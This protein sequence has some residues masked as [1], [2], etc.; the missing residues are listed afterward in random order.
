MRATSPRHR[1]DQS[2]LVSDLSEPKTSSEIDWPPTLRAELEVAPTPRRAWYLTIGPAYLTIFVWAPFFDPL[3][4][5]DLTAAGLAWLAGTA[6]VSVLLC[7]GLFYYPAAM[8]G[9]RTGRKLGVVA[10][11]TFG[12]TGSDWLTGIV[13]AGAEVVWFA[14]AIDYGIQS[15]LLGLVAGGLLPPGV[16]AGWPVG[17]AI[18]RGPLVLCLA[19]FWIFITG[20][21]SMLRLTSV[22]GALMKVYSPVAL[23]LLTIT[24]IWVL[25]GVSSFQSGE[26][27]SSRA[28]RPYPP[29]LSTI[30]IITGFFSM[31]GLMSVEWGAASARRRDVVV[32]GLVGIVLAGCWTALMSLLVVAGAVG[33]LRA[34][35]PVDAATAAAAPVLSFRWAVANGIGGG[36]AAV[37]L[38]LFGLAALAPACFSSF[39]FIRKLFARWPGI[40]RITWGWIGCTLAF[41]LVVT[42]WPGRLEAV[43]HM[44]GLVFAPAVGAIVGDHLS[45][46]GQWPGIRRGLHIPGLIAWAGGLA[47]RLVL[48]MLA[49]RGALPA[50][51]LTAS[52][53]AGFLVAALAYA[54]MAR[55]GLESPAVPIEMFPAGSGEVP[56]AVGGAA[57]G[58]AGS[59][60][61][62]V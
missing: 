52:P 57:D 33:R 45:R 30:P 53:V 59:S 32:G 23:T 28:V 35:H 27:I 42:S 10:A 50:P 17:P 19:V 37:I 46:R 4:R 41:F 58:T 40:T 36:A 44:M 43:D 18:L 34:A 1:L 25:P 24:A 9:F 16:L 55:L 62:P 49:Q 61:G 47:A 21:S 12:T 3:W 39:V 6:I 51:S 11:S 60:D 31:V 7:F 48:D 2:R 5:H 14:V 22:I 15:T 8:R 54:V 20:M 29:H 26:A 13:L 38:I 56:A